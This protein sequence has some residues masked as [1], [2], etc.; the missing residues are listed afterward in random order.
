MKKPTVLITGATAG[1][2]KATAELLAEDHFN[3]IICGRRE[4]RLKE[5]QQKFSSKTNVLTLTFDVSKKDEVFSA[6]KSLPDDFNEID[7]LINNAG[8]AHGLS[9]IQDGDV[10]DWEMMLDI[11]VKGLL[12]LSRAVLPQ[13]VRQESGHIINIGS[14]AGIDVYENG[15]VYCATK[16]AVDALS[17]GMRIDLNEAGIK[18]SEIKPGAVDTE[19]SAVRFKGDKEKAD[20]VY[21][22]FEPLVARDIA[23][24]IHFVITRPSHVNIADLLVL[25]IAQ[26]SATKIHRK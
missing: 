22:G 8:N 15:N 21:E 9:K 3:L 12:Y 1:I 10:E 11:N 18:V 4:E 25:P 5:L 20:K 16:A 7:V 24:I 13:M 6:I 17:K 2:G 26:A 14:I 23:E 19:F